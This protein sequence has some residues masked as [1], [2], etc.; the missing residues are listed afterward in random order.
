MAAGQTRDC[1]VAAGQ[2]AVFF[3]RVQRIRRASGRE[4]A[5]GA[6]PGRQEQAIALDQGD[7]RGADHAAARANS[8]CSSPRTACLS[9][10][11]VALTNCLRSNAVRSRTTW[12]A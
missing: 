9:A 3:Q 12:A 8:S 6:Q 2:G 7:E 11:E 4:A 10:S 5:A 1:E